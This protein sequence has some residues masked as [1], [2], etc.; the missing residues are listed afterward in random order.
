MDPHAKKPSVRGDRSSS[1]SPPP[2]RPFAASCSSSGSL[3]PSHRLGGSFETHPPAAAA[4]PT[5][6]APAAVPPSASSSLAAGSSSAGA[7][8]VDAWHR[9][10]HA[11]R[12]ENLPAI[13]DEGL[14]AGKSQGIGLPSEGERGAPDPDYVYVAKPGGMKF[15]AQEGGPGLVRVLSK[16]HA[17]PDVN[18]KPPGAAGMF[19]TAIPPVRDARDPSRRGPGPYS[20]TTPLTPRTRAGLHALAGGAGSA[21]SEGQAVDA[22][23][24]AFRH[25]FGIHIRAE[26]AEQRSRASATATHRESDSDSD[27]PRPPS[28]GDDDDL[29]FPLDM[30]D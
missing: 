20:F 27:E 17:P 5:F 4:A 1:P 8:D 10:L 19:D 28:G 7:L 6:V 13:H 15:T 29:Q 3:P 22:F 16:H 26:E 18:Y 14:V 2:R 9:Y 12:E 23:S 11:T 21:M 24:D 25:E 30:D